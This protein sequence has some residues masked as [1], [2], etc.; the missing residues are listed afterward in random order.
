M[1]LIVAAEHMQGG[2]FAGSCAALFGGHPGKL[3]CFGTRIPSAYVDR[4]LAREV[5][6]AVAVELAFFGHTL[7]GFARTFDPVLVFVAFG[8]QQLDDLVA[9]AGA[10]TAHCT[11]GKIDRLTDME[12]VR[13]GARFT[14]RGRR[15][16]AFSGSF[17]G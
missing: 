2:V 17:L 11:G 8:W 4:A 12:L 13:P 14:W 6:S 5:R 15:G 3:D 1:A 16:E 7:E 10:R 9:A